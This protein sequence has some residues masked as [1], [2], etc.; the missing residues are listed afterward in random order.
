MGFNARYGDDPEIN[1]IW[2][3]I[4]EWKNAALA[5]GQPVE[6]RQP[7]ASSGVAR[8]VRG[9]RPREEEEEDLMAKGTYVGFLKL[10]RELASKP[11]VTNPAG[12]AAS[13]NTARRST[14]RRVAQG[15]A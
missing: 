12:L 8:F 1:A 10:K 15:D 2:N 3:K 5:G 4:L 6:E 7:P 14:R 11:G 9:P 13:K